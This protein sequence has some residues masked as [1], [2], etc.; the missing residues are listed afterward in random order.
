MEEKVLF[1]EMGKNGTENHLFHD[2][3]FELL[4]LF[5]LYDFIRYFSF[6]LFLYI[7][8]LSIAFLFPQP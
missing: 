1:W 5:D 3:L 6:L 7:P 2:I 4:K 8:G